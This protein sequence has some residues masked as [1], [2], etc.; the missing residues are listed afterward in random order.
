MTTEFALIGA[1]RIGKVHSKAVNSMPDTRIRYVCDVY[2]PAAK[3]LAAECGAEVTN[4]DTI[5]SDDNVDAVLIAS[6]TD[7]HADLIC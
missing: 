4:L 6:A 1:G 2:E 7:T 5:F 3:E